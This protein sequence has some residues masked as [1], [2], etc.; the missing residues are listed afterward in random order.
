[1]AAGPKRNMSDARDSRF[2]DGGLPFQTGGL[3]ED[4][5]VGPDAGH[6]VR[7]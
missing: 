6:F 4:H 3:R 1:M 2:N 5:M 7:P